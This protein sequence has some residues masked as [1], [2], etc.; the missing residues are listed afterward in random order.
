MKRMK[1]NSPKHPAKYS[2][3]FIP[4]FAEKLTGCKNVL[5]PFAGTG[6]IGKIKEYGFTGN[7][8]AND[9]EREWLEPN[10]YHCDVLTFNDAEKLNYIDG[11]FDAICTSPTYGNRMADH[12]NAKDGSKRIT[13][14]HCLGHTLAQENT[15]AMQWGEAYRDK[16]V[17]IYAQI[18]RLVRPEGLFILNIS[19]H[20]RN[21][22]VVNVS[23]WHKEQILTNGFS[24]QETIEV[25]TC[26]MGFGAN[27]SR[28]TKNEYIFVFRKDET[29]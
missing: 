26:R 5:D 2:D 8:F 17:R 12:H 13:Y 21:G 14:T 22:Q 19:D 24:L 16:H 28:R 18:C 23:D 20:I 6:K 3:A 29:K 11:Y 25:V 10:I 15:G 27:S 1:D 7:I 9:I 4:I